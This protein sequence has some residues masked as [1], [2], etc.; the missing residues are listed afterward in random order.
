MKEAEEDFNAFAGHFFHQ[1]NILLQETQTS[2]INLFVKLQKGIKDQI[3]EA[4]T[5]G[6]DNK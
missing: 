1:T 6:I 4:D 5:A 3:E 2:Q